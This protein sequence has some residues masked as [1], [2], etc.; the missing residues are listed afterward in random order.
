[1]EDKALVWPEA[2]DLLLFEPEHPPIS[3][4]GVYDGNAFITL[5][6]HLGHGGEIAAEYTRY[7]LHMNILKNPLFR[8]DPK[9]AIREAFITTDKCFC[10]QAREIGDKRYFHMFST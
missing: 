10:Q 8:S 9:T 1:M 6:K 4:F 5:L 7:F 3:F 2:K